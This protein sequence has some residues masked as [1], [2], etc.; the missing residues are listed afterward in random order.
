MTGHAL[1]IG[2]AS[3]GL[4]GVGNDLDAME[5][6]LT[7]RGLRVDR[8]EGADAT[9][10]GILAACE[11][12]VAAARPG[13]AAVFYYSGHG[14]RVAPP[15]TGTD[16]PD[17]MDLQFIVPVDFRNEIASGE[18]RGITSMELSVLLGR[19]TRITRNA[20]AVFDCCHAAR[21]SRERDLRPKS[22]SDPTAYEWIRDHVEGLR[23]P[24]RP[25]SELSRATGDPE[26]VRIAA[27]APEQTAYE[28]E[29][30][31]GRRIGMLTES[32]TMALAEAGTEPVTWAAV[33]DR[34][35]RRVLMLEPGQR[36]EVAGP[37][38][39][40]LF[41]LTE[42]GVIGT[43][44]VVGLSGDRA[45]MQCAPLLGVQ[46]ED[47]FLIMP[48]DAADRDEATS[49]GSLR[50]DAVGP[51]SAEGPV[52]FHGG[53]RRVPIGAR[54]FQV[55]ATARSLP[56][57]VAS[58]GPAADAV[59]M[60]VD[61][62]P[63]LRRSE[64]GERWLAAVRID[65]DGGIGVQDRAGRLYPARPADEAGLAQVVRDLTAVARA[66]SL[67]ALVG[68]PRWALE[69]PVAFTWGRVQDGER[70]PLAASNE[71]VRV[72]QPIYLSV[73]NKG[74]TTVY[75][76]LIDIGVAARI[77]VLT[78]FAPLGFSLGPGREYVFGFDDYTG[79]L[80]GSPLAWPDR[81]DPVEARPETVVALVMSEPQ[82][83]R[84]LE[85]D[86]VVRGRG[87]APSPLEA[88]VDQ[89]SSGG[90]RD[91]PM[92]RAP[93]ARYDVHTIDFELGPS[94]DEGGFLI[95]EH[96]SPAMLHRAAARAG[97][98]PDPEP[99]TVAVRIEDLVI[100][101]NRALVFG[102][103]VRVDAIV[104]TAPQQTG[105]PAYRAST[106]RFA[107]MRRGESL[108][109][110]RML[111]YHG[112]AVDYL[113]LALWVSHDAPEAG[114]LG[115]LLADELSGFEM[116]EALAKLSESAA[117]V[118]YVGAAAT[119]VGLSAVVV[120]V[121]YRLLRGSVNDVIG[122]YRGSMLAHE[123][124]G[125]G[126]HPADGLRRVQDF[127]LAFSIE[128]IPVRQSPVAGPPTASLRPDE[129]SEKRT[130]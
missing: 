73:H 31:G 105:R 106:A 89:L 47:R 122:L 111:V 2:S 65:P 85:Q 7:E 94:P 97:R 27:C 17:L 60:Q 30:N 100:H 90:G 9:R 77:K 52:V 53:H 124:F 56:V 129:A 84:A 1:L 117:S 26:L 23:G 128:R 92:L 120:N 67:R 22:L 70:V 20:T 123:D 59:C 81:V 36:P 12:L 99:V 63:L 78:E 38:G 3:G 10:E 72:G 15:Q 44:P 13:E 64:P 40:L 21:M 5:H 4:S 104:L 87:R 46:R 19:I 18:F 69:A 45:V 110:E 118:P 37:S 126:R 51:L 113:D 91:I 93:A 119:A 114:G 28:Y 115:E 24:G 107:H 102:S 74:D 29:G 127:S 109:L 96:P 35:R 75:V 112:P 61:S 66:A 121:A 48:P 41:E 103:D 116:Q 11:N 101:R 39:R 58:G 62:Q 71:V 49:V 98:G 95:E 55:A 130:W 43:L 68:D 25:L 33:L 86:G 34:V 125:A 54:A 42:Q 57:L 16:G 8:C 6:A 14:G 108:P 82:D 32:L 83:V 80:T 79:V 76:S 88:V 50:V